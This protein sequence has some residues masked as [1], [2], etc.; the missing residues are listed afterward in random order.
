MISRKEIRFF[1]DDEHLEILE[2]LQR[3]CG[4]TARSSAVKYLITVYG[5]AEAARAKKLKQGGIFPSRAGHCE[6]ASDPTKP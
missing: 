3:M 2:S 1:L 5:A 6:S 4:F